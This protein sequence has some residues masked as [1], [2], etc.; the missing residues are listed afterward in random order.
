MRLPQKRER[1]DITDAD[2]GQIHIQF[3]NDEATLAVGQ[4]ITA[5]VDTTGKAVPLQQV[6]ATVEAE[7]S[8]ASSP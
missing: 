3:A 1:I 2:C 5:N 4:V 6:D 7:T 8:R